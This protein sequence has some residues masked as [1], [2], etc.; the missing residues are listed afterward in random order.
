MTDEQLEE[1]REDC[2]MCKIREMCEMTEEEE[3][4]FFEEF[5]KCMGENRDLLTDIS[6]W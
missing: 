5:V 2:K 3:D 4:A 1:M 6:E